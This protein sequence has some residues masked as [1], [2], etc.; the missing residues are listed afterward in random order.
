MKEKEFLTVAVPRINQRS[1]NL[2]EVQL[3]GRRTGRQRPKTLIQ[4]AIINIPWYRIRKQSNTTLIAV[5]FIGEIKE[6]SVRENKRIPLPYIIWSAKQNKWA[7]RAG[8][9]GRGL[10][11]AVI[12]SDTAAATHFPPLDKHVDRSRFLL[13]ANHQNH[14]HC[15]KFLSLFF[16]SFL[17]WRL[18]CRI[19][20]YCL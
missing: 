15:A 20:V 17:F 11:P 1:V 10:T 8:P 13:P 18:L 7:S 19:F 4:I 6:R 16:F 9:G 5:S 12:G 3:H 14:F 2:S